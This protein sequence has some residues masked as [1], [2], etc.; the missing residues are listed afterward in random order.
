[1]KISVQILGELDVYVDEVSDIGEQYVP[2]MFGAG[3][4]EE[5]RAAELWYVIEWYAAREEEPPV[6]V[7]YEYGYI[8]GGW[9]EQR[10]GRFFERV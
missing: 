4:D 1:M 9:S 6:E 3:E 8:V 10:F 2:G 5:R 7:E